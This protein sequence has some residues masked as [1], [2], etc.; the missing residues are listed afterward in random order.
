[1]R[2]LSNQ[3]MFDLEFGNL[4]ELLEFIKRDKTLCLEI[5]ENYINIY[6]RGGNI[7]CIRENNRG[8]HYEFDLKY[9]KHDRYLM[10]NKPIVPTSGPIISYLE[11]IP[12]LKQEMDRWFSQNPKLYNGHR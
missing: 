2:Y 4:K 9:F 8:Y 6:Y 10:P 12:K 5:R 1:M 3:F 7:L 11:I